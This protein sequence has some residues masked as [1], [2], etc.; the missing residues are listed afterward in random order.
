MKLGPLVARWGEET[1]GDAESS[2]RKE[3]GPQSVPPSEGS[4]QRIATLGELVRAVAADYELG[5]GNFSDI[6]DAQDK[7]LDAQLEA[8]KS[9]AERTAVWEKLLQARKVMEKKA[10]ANLRSGTELGSRANYRWARAERQRAEL[11]LAE[12]K[13]RGNSVPK[14]NA[15]A[16]KKVNFTIGPKA[17]ATGDEIVVQ[18]VWSE[19]GTLAKGDTVTVKGTCTLRSQ[20]AATLWFYITTDA[21]DAVP[22]PSRK[23]LSQKKS[24]PERRRSS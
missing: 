13:A 7:L 1:P 4:S 2:S 12:E 10:E 16:P 21:A 20:A 3:R 8:A 18:D 19:L 15:S 11:G 22:G 23:R 17:F 6:Y 9:K 5:H 24:R 14:E